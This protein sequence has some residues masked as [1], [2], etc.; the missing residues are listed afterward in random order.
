MN[1]KIAE[2]D[3]SITKLVEQKRRV[4]AE[5][6]LQRVR[7]ALSDLD[8]YGES[9]SSEGLRF[10]DFDEHTHTLVLDASDALTKVFD[11]IKD[12]TPKETP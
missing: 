1:P 3:A 7:N 12:H 4:I 10:D 11:Y 6:L 2:L 5:A 9:P 8:V